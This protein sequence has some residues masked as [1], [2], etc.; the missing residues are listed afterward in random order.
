[1]GHLSS[2]HVVITGIIRS[3]KR[4]LNKSQLDFQ[5]GATFTIFHLV[6]ERY[7][8]GATQ[9]NTMGIIFFLNGQSGQL[10]GEYLGLANVIA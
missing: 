1:M 8:I 5:T 4:V 6:V 2:E 10:S 9:T 7:C 3:I